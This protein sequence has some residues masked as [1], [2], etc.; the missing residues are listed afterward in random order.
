[1]VGLYGVEVKVVKVK[2]M[3]RLDT[4]QVGASTH[5]KGIN[6][7][8]WY[9]IK[10]RLIS[11]T[12]L[13]HMGLTIVAGAILLA[14]GVSVLAYGGLLGMAFKVGLWLDGLESWWCWWWTRRQL[15][16]EEVYERSAGTIW[17]IDNKLKLDSWWGSLETW[18]DGYEMRAK[19][20]QM[21]FTQHS[22]VYP[23]PEPIRP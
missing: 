1:M 17:E 8:S 22:P 14:I 4:S 3:N 5:L 13:P 7:L 2:D 11:G 23:K 18:Y 10:C 16:Q 20:Y 15:G 9:R 12:A 21:S 6:R 19:I